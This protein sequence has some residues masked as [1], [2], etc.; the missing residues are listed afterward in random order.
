[1]ER[2]VH[3]IAELCGV[4][5]RTLH[6]YDE[7]DLL[8]PSRVTDAGYRLYDDAAA[9]RL[10][11]ILFFRE[12]DFP[13]KSIAG[14]LDS[15]AFDRQEAFVNH[16]RLLELKRD[17]LN[18]LI[19]LVEENLKGESNMSTREFDMG[20]ID[21][22]RKQ[23]AEEVKS[24]WGDTSAYAES[25]AKAKGYGPEDWDRIQR[26]SDA[27]WDR[28][29]RLLG[30]GASVS[31]EDARAAVRA[32]QQHLTTYYYQCTRE[33]LAGLGEMYTA[34]ARFTQ[35]LDGRYGQGVAV[36]ASEA[37]REYCKAE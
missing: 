26:E 21:A 29:A 7:I 16:K 32:W 3:E 4:S 19:R 13:L 6:Y 10:Q 27:I 24:R 23:Y 5:V 9:S 2:T 8:R 31:G 14:I 28:F 17:R 1:M 33:I 11:Q 34:D 18:R 30:E 22:A 37:I 20:E 25:I 35:N 12:L 36:Y 15:P